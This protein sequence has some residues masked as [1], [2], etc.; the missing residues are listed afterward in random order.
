MSPSGDFSIDVEAHE[1][2]MRLDA[3]L[4]LHLDSC[5]RSAAASLIRSGAVR[6][7]GKIKKTGYRVRPGERITGRLPVPTPID[8]RPEPVAFGILH[9]DAHLIVIDKPPGLVIHPA[10]GHAGGTLVN[11]L[12]FHCPDL[13]EGGGIGGRIRPGIVHRLD[14]DTSGVLVVAKTESAHHHLA[15]Q[16]KDRRV[17][18]EYLALVHGVPGTAEGE[19]RLPIGRHPVERK[20]MSVHSRSSREAHTRWSVIHRYAAAAL[21]KVRIF[22]G[23]THQIR[24]HLA[25]SGMPVAGD[26]VYGK[27][28][29]QDPPVLRNI[30][31]QMLHAH[32]IAF[33][34]PA[35]GEPVAFVSPLPP[36]M[37]AVMAALETLE[38]KG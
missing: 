35:S 37:A 17:E 32:R 25:A 4:G 33:V 2:G 31:R 10:P 13:A 24:V 16:F 38:E 3:L 7:D 34:H 9:E 36:D 26:S 21:L 12:L 18:K 19:I 23:R 30:P 5:S 15:A 8:A 14:R 27:S 29:R 6:I 11:G 28:P 22:T 1:S 20:K